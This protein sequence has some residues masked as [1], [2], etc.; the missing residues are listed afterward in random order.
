[1][2]LP[3]AEVLDLVEDHKART[4]RGVWMRLHEQF[5]QFVEKQVGIGRRVERCEEDRRKQAS[6]HAL[7]DE[8]QQQGGLADTSRAEE[9]DGPVYGAADETC[10]TIEE[11]PAR[12]GEGRRRVGQLAISPGVV[13]AKA[14]DDRVAFDPQHGALRLAQARFH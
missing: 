14:T 6:L 1:M 4:V 13:G 5:E 12:P 2:P 9:H 3:V 10:E 11:G 7:A 8:L